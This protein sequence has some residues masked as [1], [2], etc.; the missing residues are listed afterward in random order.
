MAPGRNWLLYNSIMS[1]DLHTPPRSSR[2]LNHVFAVATE[3]ERAEMLER[4]AAKKRAQQQQ[5]Q[6][7]EQGDQVAL[8]PQLASET[9][10]RRS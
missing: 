6:T 10:R 1:L 4:T 9:S 3:E 8:K 7:A 2:P 5:V